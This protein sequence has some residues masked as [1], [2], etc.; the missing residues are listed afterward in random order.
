M[1]GVTAR[2]ATPPARRALYLLLVALAFV[3][4]GPASPASAHAYLAGSTPGDG[5]VVASA[6]N[7][8]ALHFSESVVLAATHLDV[9]DADGHHYSPTGMRLLGGSAD[10]E[11][12]TSV[13]AT[14]PALPK[15]AYRV[16]WETLSSDDLHRTSGVVIF[17][18]AKPVSA[19]PFSE[20]RPPADEVGLRWLTFLALALAFGGALCARLFRRHDPQSRA[21]MRCEWLSAT[22]AGAGALLAVGLLLDQLSRGGWA[23]G[24]L[25]LGPY[26]QRWAVREAGFLLLLVAVTG[27]I[28]RGGSTSGAAGAAFAA[29]AGAACIGSALI[30]HAGASRPLSLTRIVADAAHLAAAATWAGGVIALAVMALAVR[31][32]RR[33]GGSQGEQL[34]LTLRAFAVPAATCVG[35]MIVT[36]V[37]LASDVVGSVDAAVTTF[38]GRALLVKLVL[39][40]VA[41]ALGLSHAVRLR[42]SRSAGTP[43]RTLAFEATAAAAILLLAGVLTSSQPATEPQFVQQSA[44]PTV[45]VVDGQAMDL[46]ET[47]AL[48]PNLPGRNVA[49]VGVFDTRRP[50][51]AALSAVDVTLLSPTGGVPVTVAAEKLADGRWSAPVALSSTGALKVLITVHRP[52]MRD[53]TA[54]Y[55]WTVGEAAATAAP[56][57]ATVSRQPVGPLL[58]AVAAWLLALLAGAAAAMLWRRRRTLR[59]APAVAAHDADAP[60]RDREPDPVGVA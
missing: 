59:S 9:V 10:T 40:L 27:R 34:R 8:L 1:A 47:L 55:R 15:N 60:A 28:R 3:L 26:G 14:L 11:D 18:V 5:T 51:P 35:V 2:R 20:P 52:G 58:R 29:G 24:R 33:A 56:A 6:P 36:G 25:L 48:R 19:A 49:L 45:P 39:A 22:G 42:R 16:S 30:G 38:Y 46:Q 41:G 31:P 54:T 23:A 17:G 44:A 12:P 7:E 53:A 57:R 50:A 37:Y 13:V 4:A 32:L 21:A 43:R